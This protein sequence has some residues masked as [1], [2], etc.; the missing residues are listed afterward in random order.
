[1]KVETIL[2]PTDFSKL[3]EQAVDTG[4]ALARA[5]SAR[6]VLLHVMNRPEDLDK[7]SAAYDEFYAYTRDQMSGLLEEV[8]DKI[9]KKGVPANM[10]LLI[11]VPHEEIVR[12]ALREKADLIVMGTHGRKG[13]D[14]LR[15]GSQT[16]Q[17]VRSAHCPVVTLKGSPKQA[18][19]PL[20]GQLKPVTSTA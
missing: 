11:G 17:V 8:C 3:S 19:E 9:K 13:L 5:F 1:M 4:V 18:E 16:E 7:L 20:K 12:I 15:M 2:I 10:E 14:R 6:I